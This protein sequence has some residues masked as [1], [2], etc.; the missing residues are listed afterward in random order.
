MIAETDVQWWAIDQGISHVVMSHAHGWTMRLCGIWGPTGRE[1]TRHN[2]RV[3]RHCRAAMK[4]AH[5][6]T[7]PPSGGGPDHE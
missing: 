7:A 2:G 3:C 6:V 5:V 4:D 1:A